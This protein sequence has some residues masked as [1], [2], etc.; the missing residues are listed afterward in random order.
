MICIINWTLRQFVRVSKLIPAVL[1]SQDV[2][3][4]KQPY[5]VNERLKGRRNGFFVECGAYDGQSIS[6]SLFFEMEKGWTGLLV[7]PQPDLYSAVLRKNRQV[8]CTSQWLVHWHGMPQESD[9][10]LRTDLGL[11]GRVLGLGLE[12]QGLRLG[13]KQCMLFILLQFSKHLLLQTTSRCSTVLPDVFIFSKLYI[14]IN[15][16][17]EF[18]FRACGPWAV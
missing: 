5:M 4:R 11:E 10:Y 8:I 18:E 3:Q 15:Y 16:L 1:A 7:E 14:N 6:N 17:S 2:D 9:D 12:G 13:L